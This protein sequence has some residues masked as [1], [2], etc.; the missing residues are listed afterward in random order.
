MS[1]VD[2]LI[3]GPLKQE[4]R[5]EAALKHIKQDPQGMCGLRESGLWQRKADT[6]ICL[7][8]VDSE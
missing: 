1:F 2:L 6:E 8:R 5:T 7:I 3:L 4:D